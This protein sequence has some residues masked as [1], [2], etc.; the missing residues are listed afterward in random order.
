M[1]VKQINAKIMKSYLLMVLVKNV[2]NTLISL[3]MANT[4]LL[5]PVTRYRNY[6]QLE[7][8]KIVNNLLDNKEMV[9]HADLTHATL[10][11]LSKS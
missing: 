2:R 7:N 3:T 5:I 4:V 1:A 10:E 8:A 9:N 11:Q 6:F